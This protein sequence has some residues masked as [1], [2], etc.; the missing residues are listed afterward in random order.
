MSTD[1]SSTRTTD[2]TSQL[3]GYRHTYDVVLEQSYSTCAQSELQAE[4]WSEDNSTATLTIVKLSETCSARDGSKAS[5]ETF[6]MEIVFESGHL[7]K[8]TFDNEDSLEQ[9]KRA[10]ILGRNL[11]AQ[12]QPDRLDLS[13]GFESVRLLTKIG[14]SF[15]VHWLSQ[16]DMNYNGISPDL[17]HHVRNYIDQEVQKD[18][19]IRFPLNGRHEG[20]AQRARSCLAYAIL[21][22]TTGTKSCRTCGIKKMLEKIVSFMLMHVSNLFDNTRQPLATQL[23]RLERQSSSVR[24]V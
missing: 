22:D 13:L 14:D 21:Q 7:P 9:A 1:T 8:I 2:S 6:S 3:T 20:E 16:E 17:Y 10:F 24:T 5:E 23:E 12:I 18:T 11:T 15:M 19:R 4:A